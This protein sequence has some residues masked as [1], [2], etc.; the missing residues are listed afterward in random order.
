M[1]TKH[2]DPAVVCSEN[3]LVV[4]GGNRGDDTLVAVEVMDTSSRQWFTASSLPHNFYDVST[5]ICGD[6][7]YLMGGYG[8]SEG[9]LSVITCSLTALLESCHSQSLQ[10]RMKAL[11]TDKQ[12]QVWKK[13]ADVP[14]YFTSCTTLCGQVIADRP[15]SCSL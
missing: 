4:A 14:V 5:T 1:P 12:S 10:A 8:V 11:F 7:M 15:D 2:W 13:A 9:S 6:N 3:S